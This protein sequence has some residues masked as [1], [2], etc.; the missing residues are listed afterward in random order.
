MGPYNKDDYSLNL[1]FMKSVM[2][3]VALATCFFFLLTTSFKP[4]KSHARLQKDT[5]YYWYLDNGTVYDD[6]NDV[7]GEITRL[8]NEYGVYIDEDPI[9][10]TLIAS[11]YGIKGYPH[12][13][14]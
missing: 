2:L 6:W 5:F 13:V 7:S 12:V 14:Y 8:E 9:D 10:G 3:K 4:A 11:G 1:S